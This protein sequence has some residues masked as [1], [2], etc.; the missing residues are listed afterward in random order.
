[1]QTYTKSLASDFSGNLSIGQFNQE[2]HANVGIPA[3]F[4]INLD[5]DVVDIIFSSG[6]SAPE[7]IVL[8]GLISAHTPALRATLLS[9]IEALEV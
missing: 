1:M 9:R 4:C 2:I 7:I 6:L 3:T 5:G 8:D